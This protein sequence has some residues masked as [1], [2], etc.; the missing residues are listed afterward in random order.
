METNRRFSRTLEEAF[1]PGHRSSIWPLQ[2]MHDPR[3]YS[4]RWSTAIALVAIAA[5]FAIAIFR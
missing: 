5:V 1:G 3:D 4:P 2:P